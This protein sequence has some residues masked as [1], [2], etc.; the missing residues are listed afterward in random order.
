MQAGA[1]R[2][3]VIVGGGHAHVAV[4]KSL[5]M[6]PEPAARVTVVSPD[7]YATYT[8]MVPGVLAGQYQPRDAQI[9][10]R[11]L[12]A[13]ADAAF[14]RDRVVRVDPERRV[15]DLADRP[16]LT[17]DLVSFDI[18][19]R[20]FGAQR[21][22]GDAPV[23]MVKP[24]E[25]AL[26][27]IEG[28][29]GTAPPAGGHH[30]VVVGAGAG[31]TE[32]AF[33]LAARLQDGG[34]VTLCDGAPVPVAS[35]SLRVSRL[36]LRELGRRGIRFVGTAEV[37]HV[38]AREVV[39]T[40][41]QS[42]PATLIVWA[43]GAA[44]PPLF[45][46]SGLAV[47]ARGFLLLNDE[48]RC[49]DHPEIFAAGDC[50][51]M[52][53]HPTLPK[54]GVY[55]V[56]EGPVLTHNLRAALRGTARTQVYHPQRH[57]LSL[58][59]TGDG[60]AIL[61][62]K[63][64]A[65]RGR[66]VWRVKDRIDRAF[67][68]RYARPPLDPTAGMSRAMV[69]CG[70]CAA[71]VSADA[72]TR[73]LARLDLPPAE[74]ILVGLRPPDDAAV[75][76]HPP[77]ALAVATLDAFPPFSAD[78][79][80]VGQ[81]AAVN[82]ASDLYAMGAEGIAAMALACLPSSDDVDTEEQLTLFLRGALA[83]LGELGVALVGGHSVAGEQA[84]FGFA[85]HGWVEPDAI[86]RKSGARPGDRL[87][88]TKPLGTGVVLAAARM[89]V[90]PAEWVE[91]AHASMTR[92]NGPA[93]RLLKTHGVRAC[94]DVTGFGLAGHLGE[95]LRASG[96]GAQL[97]A[98]AIP[99][100]PGARELLAAGWR[101]SFHAANERAGAPGQRSSPIDTVLAALMHDPQT[102]GG[103]LAAVP[104]AAL[105]DLERACGSAGQALYVLGEVT[106]GPPTWELMT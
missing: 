9:D 52:I 96:A 42:L 43:T 50:A 30:A 11:A 3:L 102:S 101:S 24:I 76:A 31:G 41:G 97:D 14:V 34:S 94:T 93:M 75:F 17:Y 2:H 47:D 8:G 106:D 66:W 23:V 84:L 10:V 61:S 54:A 51:T 73:A 36:V 68:Q 59:N 69:P 35:H 37:E 67:I 56:R 65:A 74:S 82:A 27:E 21:V 104:A 83:A 12:A 55:A 95:L 85:M 100:L 48:L 5:A 99:A 63:G 16:P 91:A 57:A 29:L 80:L 22:G 58:L 18:G 4:L 20:P 53:A 105:A 15:L 70:G 1:R 89:G 40:S 13:R 78:V 79:F 32:I 87:V 7:S 44:G 60:A 90:A 6:R 88:L 28:A 71:K 19:S 98:A 81:I 49:P 92:S 38:S 77:G 45:A 103:L 64:L 39:L 86:L 25:R 72:L 62:Y 26:R 46:Q 33:A